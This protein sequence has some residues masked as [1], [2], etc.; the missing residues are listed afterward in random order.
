[1]TT[2]KPM[3]EPTKP[4]EISTAGI[5][6]TSPATSVTPDIDDTVEVIA[7]ASPG[8]SPVGDC[9]GRLF[10]AHKNDCSKYF[11]CN[12]GHLSENSCPSGLLWNQD[13]CDWPENTKCQHNKYER[14]GEEFYD[15]IQIDAF[16]PSRAI[17]EDSVEKRDIKLHGEFVI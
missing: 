11:L 6:N 2:E 9:G 1:M 8:S 4:T 14:E 15:S 17:K 5:D 12:F 13:R 3:K 10:I 16:E 7:G